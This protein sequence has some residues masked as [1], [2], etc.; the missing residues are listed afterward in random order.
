MIS[1][2]RAGKNL[3]IASRFSTSRIRMSGKYADIFSMLDHCKFPFLALLLYARANRPGAGVIGRIFAKSS[4][5][6]ST[7][8][9]Q[10]RKH[11]GAFW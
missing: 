4:V 3:S 11:N 9:Y 6:R 1:N 8:S 2:V 7:I 5:L 10:K